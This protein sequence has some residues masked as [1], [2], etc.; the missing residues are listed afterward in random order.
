[1]DTLFHAIYSG[2]LYKLTDD[3][4]PHIQF[5]IVTI[6]ALVGAISCALMVK[7]PHKSAV[8]EKSLRES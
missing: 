8:I 7:E 2:V 1:M 5:G 3:F 4:E 6:L